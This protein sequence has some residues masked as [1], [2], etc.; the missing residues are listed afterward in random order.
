MGG[1]ICAA[2]PLANA[3][4]AELP[5]SA[6]SG[7]LRREAT[8]SVPMHIDVLREAGSEMCPDADAV[9]RSLAALYPERFFRRESSAR[10]ASANIVIQIRPTADG[11]AALLELGAPQTGK[12]LISERGAACGGLSDAIAVAVAMLVE[13]EGEPVT[14][15]NGFDAAPKPASTSGSVLSAATQPSNVTAAEEDPKTALQP[16]SAPDQPKSAPQPASAATNQQNKRATAGNALTP[17]YPLPAAASSP[18]TGWSPAFYA[19]VLGTLSAPSRPAAGAVLGVD[20]SHRSGFGFKLN[21]LAAWALPAKEGTGQVVARVFGGMAGICVRRSLNW[22]LG[23]Q[24]CFDVGAGSMRVDT[25]DYPV[26]YVATLHVP[27]VVA[28]PQ[29]ALIQ[30][31]TSA[32]QAYWSVGA[33]ANLRREQF[34]VEGNPRSTVE[35]HALGIS[36]EIGIRFSGP[37]H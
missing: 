18:N 10:T 2:S 27:W 13:P 30:R 11:H 28:G 17:V 34:V 21:G 29:L 12:R 7:R 35:A 24:A 22:Q 16:S 37:M 5:Q 9:F 36:A 32:T 19:G 20:V 26:V 31:L 25:R 1:I 8:T 6:T 15:A 4:P 14:G 33:L 23:Y 3:A